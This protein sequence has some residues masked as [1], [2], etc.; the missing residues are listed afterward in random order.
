MTCLDTFEALADKDCMCIALDIGRSE[1]AI[2]DPSKL[3]IKDVIPTFLTAEA[4]LDSALFSINR[5]GEEAHG[6][7]NVATQGK[8]AM[9]LGRENITGVMPLYLF[10]E[11]WGIA[12]RKMPPI[13][14]FMCTLDVMGYA[15]S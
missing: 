4:F 1:A 7:F 14:G 3:V 9:G 15:S 11:H 2:S 8:L 12:R 5:T 13:L 10:E 6:G